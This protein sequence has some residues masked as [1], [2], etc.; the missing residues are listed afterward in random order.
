MALCDGARANHTR[1]SASSPFEQDG[2]VIILLTRYRIC[3]RRWGPLERV[4]IKKAPLVLAD[5]HADDRLGDECCYTTPRSHVRHALQLL[6]VLTPARLCP[7]LKSFGISHVSLRFSRSRY[8]NKGGTEVKIYSHFGTID[9][10]SGIR[11]DPQTHA[12]PGK[13]RP[14]SPPYVFRDYPGNTCIN[15]GQARVVCLWSAAQR[16][17][18]QTH[19]PRP[20]QPRTGS[21]PRA[22]PLWPNPAEQARASLGTVLSCIPTSTLL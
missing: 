18:H 14:S 21:R 12:K 3:R 17:D 1:C 6:I 5:R 4:A 15:S 7:L 20:Q 22:P 16:D 9:G 11:T 10:N 2:T 13:H 8:A 19:V